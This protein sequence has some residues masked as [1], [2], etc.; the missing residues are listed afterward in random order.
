MLWWWICI[1]WW[2]T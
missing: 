2:R 1:Q